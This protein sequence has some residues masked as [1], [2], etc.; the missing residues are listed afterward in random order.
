M[1]LNRCIFLVITTKRLE[2]FT[3]SF[4]VTNLLADTSSVI[5]VLLISCDNVSYSKYSLNIHRSLVIPHVKSPLEHS[6]VTSF[7]VGV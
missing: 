4:C 5:N 7:F 1:W 2:V 3:K 6:C